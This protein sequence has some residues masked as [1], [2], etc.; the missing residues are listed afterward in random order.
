MTR[1]LLRSLIV[2]AIVAVI[3]ASSLTLFAGSSDGKGKPGDWIACPWP[4]CMA[5]CILGAEPEV[6]CRYDGGA[7]KTTFACCC[8]GGGDAEYRWL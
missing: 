4:P 7:A 1:T 2:V 6:L 5:A 3:G 8:C